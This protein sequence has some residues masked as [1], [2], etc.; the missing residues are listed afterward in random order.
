MQKKYRKFKE[1]IKGK[2]FRTLF[3]RNGYKPFLLMN[4]EQIASVPIAKLKKG[5]VFS[6]ENVEIQNRNKITQS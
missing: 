2:G 6:L 5:I 3:R 4:S 1:P